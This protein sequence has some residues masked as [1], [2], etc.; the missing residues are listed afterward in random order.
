[1]IGVLYN[2]GKVDVL[3]LLKFS[4]SHLLGS[5]NLTITKGTQSATG[6]DF[7]NNIKKNL[8]QPLKWTH[9]F[10]LLSHGVI[11]IV[12]IN[13]KGL[14][15]SSHLSTKSLSFLWNI[16]KLNNSGECLIRKILQKFRS[17]SLFCFPLFIWYNIIPRHMAN[18][19]LIVILSESKASEV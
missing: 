19:C 2:N 15:L 14:E 16:G 3:E 9:V 1:M 7:K 18:Y 13:P 6:T 17:S 10:V 11:W 5:T 8:W 12:G 4:V